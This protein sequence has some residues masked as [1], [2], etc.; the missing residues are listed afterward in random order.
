ML[1]KAQALEDQFC[2]VSCD[3]TTPELFE[4][5]IRCV[6]AAVEGIPANA[7]SREL[8]S[9]IVQLRDIFRALAAPSRRE[10]S[11]LWAELYVILRCGHSA[12]ALGM[13]HSDQFDRYDFSSDLLCLEVKAT[14]QG[15][16][17][18]DFALEQLEPPAEGVGLFASLLLQPLTG[19]L[20]VLDLARRIEDAAP[21]DAR[22]RLKLR[23]NIAADWARTFLPV[24]TGSS[25]CLLPTGI[26]LST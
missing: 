2:L 12:A 8:E 14:V 25:T 20:G 13:W 6:A 19:G 17:V 22:L 7:G 1:V 24:S 9:C 26:W 4:L 21:G 23:Q 18:H 5:F 16:R 11:G 10:L 3:G 15:T